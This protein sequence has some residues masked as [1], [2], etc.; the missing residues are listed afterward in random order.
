MR[1]YFI[2][3]VIGVI[4]GAI[5]TISIAS[6]MGMKEGKMRAARDGGFSIGT[7]VLEQSWICAP[8]TKHKT[9]EEA[10]KQIEINHAIS[11]VKG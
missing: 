5:M 3:A 10:N 11:T 4:G 9:I 1:D 8:I 7:G 2:G 6:N